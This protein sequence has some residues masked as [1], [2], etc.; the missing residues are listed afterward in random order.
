MAETRMIGRVGNILAWVGF[1][2]FFLGVFGLA[3]RTVML[4]GLALIVASL[5][6]YFTEEFQLRG[7]F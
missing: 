7:R 3:P 1:L 2:G 6:A 5:I 4:I